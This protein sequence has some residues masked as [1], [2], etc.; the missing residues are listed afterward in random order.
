M[1]AVALLVSAPVIGLVAFAVNKFLEAW[2][3][4]EKISKIR[5]ELTEIGMKGQ[6]VEE[7]TEQITITVSG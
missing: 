4:I 3:R 5:A 7:L 2:E 1:P 6:A